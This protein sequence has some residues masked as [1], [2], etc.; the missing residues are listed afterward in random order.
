MVRIL[1]RTIAMIA[2]PKP[3]SKQSA[4]PAWH[5]HF[6]SMLP[7]IQRLASLAFR[8]LSPEMR[9]DRIEEVIAHAVVAFKALYD[10][11]KVDLAY[12]I[13]W[14]VPPNIIALE[15]KDELGQTGVGSG[16]EEGRAGQ[17]GEPP[18]LH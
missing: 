2:S 15:S 9:G 7:Q 14:I 3:T 5:D 1:E 12:P 4:V 13:R 16:C 18:N 6:L 17:L 10:Q 11:G 8:G